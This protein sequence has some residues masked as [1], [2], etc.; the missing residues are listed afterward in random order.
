MAYDST[1]Q[2]CVLFGGMNSTGGIHK[3]TWEYDVNTNSWEE[4]SPFFGPKEMVSNPLAF[5]SS[6]G[7]TI[8]V[9]QD[10]AAGDMQTWAYDASLDS[11]TLQTTGGITT[12]GSHAMAYSVSG[13]RTVVFGGAE[14]MNVLGDTWEYEYSTKVWT[15]FF[16]SGP[17]ARY[18]AAMTYHSSEG[19]VYLFGGR[20]PAAF[21]PDTW[22]RPTITQTWEPVTVL[23]YPDPRANP[24]L[25]YDSTNDY[26]IMCCGNDMTQ[27]FNDTWVL[28]S[29]YQLQGMYTS[30]VNNT[31]EANVNYTAVYLNQSEGMWPENTEIRIQIATSTSETGPFSYVG[32]DGTVFTWYNQSST[33]IPD[34][35]DH[36]QYITYSATLIS[37][38]GKYSPALDNVAISYK[39]DPSPPY[40]VKTYPEN[41]QFNVLT[42]TCIFLNFSEPMK[43][44]SVTVDIWYLN[45]KETTGITFDWTWSDN[46]KLKLCPQTN[47]QESR[48]V[49]VWVNGTDLEDFALV[50]NP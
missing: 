49:Q 41:T 16:T 24:A 45:P 6:A 12:R 17:Q 23:D 22:K 44:L 43:T 21:F 28:G 32:P 8:L 9:G 5:D 39:I 2:V 38:N 1:N 18:D 11:W 4:T 29:S 7:K 30:K 26:L 46:T 37:W 25:V 47:F 14:G 31:K 48:A 35:H 15:N 19:A 42:N 27:R 34:F 36:Q 40:L 10:F 3:D 50:P 20:T 13:V 33:A